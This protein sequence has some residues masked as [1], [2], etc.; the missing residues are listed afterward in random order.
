M[1]DLRLAVA[2]NQWITRYLIGALSESG[3]APSLVINMGDHWADRISGYMDLARDAAGI[4]AKLYRPVKY[5]L[6]S[7]EDE[8][9][10][11]AHDIDVLLAFGWQRLIPTWLI[12]RCGLGAFGVHGGP[13]LPPRCRGRAGFNWAIL[14]GYDHFH[15]Y[16]FRLAPGVDDGD[17]I[18][19]ASFDILPQDDIATVYHKNCVVSTRLFLDIVANAKTGIPSGTPQA[20][21]GATY[22][23]KRS[24]ENGGIDWGA[25]AKR[26]VDL[27]RALAPPYPGAFSDIAG[28]RVLFYRAQIFD[29]RISYAGAPGTIVD[30][31]P[32]GDFVVAATDGAIYVREW[33]AAGAFN[34][35]KGMIFDRVSGTPLP[36]PVL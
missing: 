13:E 1:T 5:S 32:N 4:G 8:A 25:P 23:P 15:M 35:R 2:G 10:L 6:K 27:V 17:I 9:G 22:L 33:N 30:V 28:E 21:E 29:T 3:F 7:A 16:A 18:G 36:D 20:P 26:I 24:P 12:E 31:F 34:P 14:L 11:A 19:L